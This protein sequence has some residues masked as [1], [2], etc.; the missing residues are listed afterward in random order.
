MPG[1]TGVSGL[2]ATDRRDANVT[3]TSRHD[4]IVVAGEL[5]REKGYDA[6]TLADI[7]ERVGVLKG[8]LYHHISSKEE[9]LVEVASG[10]ISV[11]L[12]EL[13]EIVAAAETSDGKMLR[14]ISMHIKHLHDDYPEIFVYL[15][16]R[17]GSDNS[18]IVK[19]SRRYQELIVGLIADGIE[20][21]TFRDDI[22]PQLI[23]FSVLGACNWMHKWYQPDGDWNIARIQ[24]AF[25]RLFLD[26]ILSRS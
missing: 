24:E 23:A 8:S 5:F 6:T 3:K 21:G 15:Q 13:E 1:P 2:S 9:L 20:D 14:I 26:G 18:E 17:F 16:E 22:D 7:A 25:G 12:A 10:P 4:I 19:M 11:M